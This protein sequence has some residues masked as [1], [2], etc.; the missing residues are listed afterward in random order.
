MEYTDFSTILRAKNSVFTFKDIVLLWKESVPALAKRR[1]HHYVKTGK[2]QAI[3]R[4]IYAKDENYNRLELATKIYTP[5]Y[6]S[7]ETILRKEGVIFQHYETIFV[8]TYL[9]REIVVDGQTYVYKKLK[10][11][12]LSN[13]AGLIK[14]EG[15]MEASKERAF[16]DALYLYKSYHFDNLRSI[17][18]KTCFALLPVYESKT[19]EKK[20]HEYYENAHKH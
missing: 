7:L 4:G 12:I 13:P 19:L 8:I 17:N 2:L 9:S 11:T 5:S 16:M 14:K 1:I 10:D 3:R 18:W 6:V 20:L 15:Y